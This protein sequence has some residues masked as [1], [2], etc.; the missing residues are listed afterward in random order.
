MRENDRSRTT[1][2]NFIFSPLDRAAGRLS[3]LHTAVPFGNNS[4][5][6][7]LKQHGDFGLY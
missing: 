3:L 7:M 2:E 6:D 5:T 1:S 4:G